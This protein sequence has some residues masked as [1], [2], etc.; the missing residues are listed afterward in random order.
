MVLSAD[1]QVVPLLAEQLVVVLP[2]G[3]MVVAASAEERVVPVRPIQMVVDS[4]SLENVV[5]VP[6]EDVLDVRMD[7]I[8]LADRSIVG[9]VVQGDADGDVAS[10]GS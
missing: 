10:K 5:A 7:D 4:V 1:E 6:A 9:N 2:S 8:V 3:K